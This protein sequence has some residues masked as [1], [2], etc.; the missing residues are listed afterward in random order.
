[1]ND[2]DNPAFVRIISDVCA[3]YREP[4]SEFSLSVWMQACKPYSIDAIRRALTAHATDPDRGQFAPKPADV[5]RQLRGSTGDDALA[6]W[7][8]VI[9]QVSAVGRDGSPK[10]TP[11]ESAALTAIGGW[12]SLCNAQEDQTPHL[13][14]MFRDNYRAAVV[15]EERAA[16]LDPPKSIAELAGSVIK[17][18]SSES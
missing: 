9:S 5:I 16:L 7:Q 15:V 11:A 2:S 13:C 17:R 3:F 6:A 4:V 18:I 12:R 14:R 10:L 8:R 1:M